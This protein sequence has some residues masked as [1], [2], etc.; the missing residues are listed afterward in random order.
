MSLPHNTHTKLLEEVA[1]ISGILNHPDWKKFEDW[2]CVQAR[3]CFLSAMTTEN[4]DQQRDML[5]LARAFFYVMNGFKSEQ[6]RIEEVLTLNKLR[7][8]E[9]AR[10]KVID[11][12][13]HGQ[14]RPYSRRKEMLNGR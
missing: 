2:C 10:E 1:T 13:T 14:P 5:S 12:T 11:A 3:T 8:D 9:E 6:A 4:V 7:E